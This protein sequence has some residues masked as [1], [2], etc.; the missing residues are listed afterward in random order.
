MPPSFTDIAIPLAMTDSIQPEHDDIDVLLE[1][2]LVDAHGDDEQ[3]TAIHE[4]MEAS[5]ELPVDVLVAGEPM[6]LVDVNYE[7]NTR[8]GLVA[9]CVRMDSS[10]HKRRVS[11]ADV[12]IQSNTQAYRFVC[13]YCRWL[14]VEPIAM[15]AGPDVTKES[16][17][18]AEEE[19]NIDM[20]DTV[21]LVVMV[22]KQR[23]ARC[24][25]LTDQ[26]V[27]TLK[28]PTTYQTVPG[29]IVTVQPNKFWHFKGHPYLSGE[30]VSTRI[31]VEVLN[32]PLL[33]ISE[34]AVWDPQLAFDSIIS[35]L[36]DE[37]GSETRGTN[38][39]W[40]K[41]TIARG[42]RP[43]YEM[44]QIIPGLDLDD[45]DAIELDPIIEANEL[46]EQGDDEGAH[47]IFADLLEADLRCLDAHAHLGNMTFD[48]SPKQALMHYN[49]GVEIG[50]QAVGTNFRSVLPW[51]WPNN[52]PFLRCMFGYGLSLWKL[53]RWQQAVLLFESIVDLNPTDELGV[54]DMLPEVRAE[55]SYDESGG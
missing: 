25:Q 17:E 30:I 29:Q 3:L 4:G 8:R 12:Q 31:D 54:R 53:E 11:L 35:D 41:A 42:P 34:V 2:L 21:D 49:V 20:T 26:R 22:T 32:L 43:V 28:A 15:H 18:R 50:L 14:C 1:E 48:L 36:A 45:I 40:I 33:A 46:R 7:G 55:Q 44:Q 10:E 37:D 52:R 39:A 24:R 5:I 9:Q 51:S 23:A 38:S 13:A 47:Q 16:E 6:A 27:I 19:I